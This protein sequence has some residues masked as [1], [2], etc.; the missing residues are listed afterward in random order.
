[1]GLNVGLIHDVQA[2]SVAQLIPDAVIGIVAG[3]HSVEVVLLHQADVLHHGSDRQR[4]GHALIVLVAVHALDQDP[5][6]VDQKPP[7]G[8]LKA[9]EADS[10]SAMLITK[11]ETHIIE[12]GLLAAPQQ[13][14]LDID[15]ADEPS[16]LCLDVPSVE[17][18]PLRVIQA[19]FQRLLVR[20]GGYPHFNS[21]L[22]EALVHYGSHLGIYHRHLGNAGKD[23]APMQASQ[24]P[25]VLV[26]D[27][28]GIAVAY[29]DQGE[30][31]TSQAYKVGHIEA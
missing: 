10:K 4:L 24:P 31:V 9:P 30:G 23:D 20:C 28:G 14:M 17:Q 26:L 13:G 16:I 1:M 18:R 15:R 25:L 11:R 2:V 8:N 12:R 5:L 21:S 22:L 19:H 7:L 6:A 27:I 3:A 29:Y